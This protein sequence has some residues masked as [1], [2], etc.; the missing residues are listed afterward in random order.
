MRL[1]HLSTKN[2]A[3]LLAVAV[4]I[5]AFGIIAIVKLPIQMLPNL[6]YAEINVFTAWRS[7]AP[8]EVEAE[9]H[10]TPG[11]KHCEAFRA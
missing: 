3:A 11:K 8:Q 5:L 6:E 2:P 9:H 7:S 1:I 4:L 10:Q